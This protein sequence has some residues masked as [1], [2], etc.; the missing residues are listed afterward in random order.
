MKKSLKDLSLQKERIESFKT[1]ESNI[2]KKKLFGKLFHQRINE[3]VKSYGITDKV[4][5]YI[6]DIACLICAAKYGGKSDNYMVTTSMYSYRL[7]GVANREMDMK[8]Y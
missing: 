7:N 1:T 5:T 3:I 6:P 4:G 8:I 2:S